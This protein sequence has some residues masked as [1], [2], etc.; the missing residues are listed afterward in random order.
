MLI[1]TPRVVFSAIVLAKAISASVP[2]PAS[3]DYFDSETFDVETTIPLPTSGG[4]RKVVLNLDA[5]TSLLEPLP[6]DSQYIG[7]EEEVDGNAGRAVFDAEGVDIITHHSS[8]YQKL[9]NLSQPVLTWPPVDRDDEVRSTFRSAGSNPREPLVEE[10]RS[11]PASYALLSALGA[12]L[13]YIVMMISRCKG[14]MNE[15]APKQPFRQFLLPH[16]ERPVQGRGN[17]HRSKGKSNARFC[18]SRAAPAAAKPSQAASASESAAT[19]L[20]AAI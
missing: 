20:Q 5:R 18:F 16:V 11:P 2:S 6:Y 7:R 15:L 3:V 19:A 14:L 8:T 1:L 12:S 10:R 17:A 9:H 13:G 4:G